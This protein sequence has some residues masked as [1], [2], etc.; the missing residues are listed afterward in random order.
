MPGKHCD[1]TPG[2]L[3]KLRNSRAFCEGVNA[4]ARDASAT[5]IYDQT[6]LPVDYDDYEK[7]IAYAA[8]LAGSAL[9]GDTAVCCGVRG[10]TV[11]V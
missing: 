1:G 2:N 11:P 6:A 5:N 4:R 8:S 9:D 10:L 7:G 3:A